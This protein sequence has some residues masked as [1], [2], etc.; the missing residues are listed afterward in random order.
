MT[1]TAVGGLERKGLF[2]TVHREMKIGVKYPMEVEEHMM[3]HFLLAKR[4]RMWA[5]R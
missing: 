5:H 1:L 2:A 3:S 4:R